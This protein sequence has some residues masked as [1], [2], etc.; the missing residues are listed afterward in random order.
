MNDKVSGSQRRPPPGKMQKRGVQM[1]RGA[2]SQNKASSCSINA[3]SPADYC[4]WLVGG[5]S[6]A[7]RRWWC[8]V[9]HLRKECSV[10]H[11]FPSVKPVGCKVA[12]AEVGVIWQ[13]M[14]WALAQAGN[15]AGKTRH[16]CA[17]MRPGTQARL[18]TW[19]QLSPHHSTFFFFHFAERR[20]TNKSTHLSAAA[21][22]DNCM[23]NAKCKRKGVIRPGR[24]SCPEVCDEVHDRKLNNVA[25]KKQMAREAVRKS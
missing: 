20:G 25:D 13:V 4:N 15:R 14:I 22:P 3:A 17:V 12:S 7:V 16:H 8:S 5:V 11:G 10:C 9:V 19:T 18:H 6:C 1:E 24:C 2:G 21:S 23:Q